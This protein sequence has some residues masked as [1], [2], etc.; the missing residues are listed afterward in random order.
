MIN[1]L[2]NFS[3]P[4]KDPILIFSLVL[5]IILLA[6]LVLKKLR[7]PSIIGLIIA[8]MV[9]G[10]QGFNVLLRDNSIVLFGTVGLLYIMFLAALELDLN[11]FR[12]N[13]YK[14]IV[15]GVLTFIVPLIIGLLF[16]H[17][18][19]G[20]GLMPSL[21]IASMF[22]THTMVAYPIVSKFGLTKNEAVNIAVGGTIITDS[23]VLLVLAIVTNSIQGD[24]N[25][26]F[27]LRLSGSLIIF[28]F[29]IFWGFPKIGYWFFKNTE[30]ESASQYIFVLAMVFLA[31]FMAELAGMEPIIGA[32]M[33]GFA[34][35]KLIPHSSVLMNR[36]EFVGNALFIPFFLISVGMLV[37]LKVLF[38]DTDTLLFAVLLTT[39]AVTTKWVAAILSRYILGLNRL[40]GNLLFGLSVSHAAAILAVVLTGMKLGLFDDKVLNGSILLILVTCLIA[41]F[42][43]EITGKKLAILEAENHEDNQEIEEKILI[44]LQNY[45]TY[46]RLLDF[47]FLVK[48]PKSTEPLYPLV[49]VKDDEESRHNI[50]SG[51]KF[52]EKAAQYASASGN[53]VQKVTR[54]DINLASGSTR[55]IKELLISDIILDWDV[56][57]K[58]TD[59]LFGS[60][61]RTMVNVNEQTMFLCNFIQPLNTLKKVILA[62]PP[63]AELEKGFYNWLNKIIIIAKQKG[64]SIVVFS[65]D[66]TYDKII[67]WI[68]K[69]RINLKISHSL[70]ENWTDFL[71]IGRNVQN[72]DLF[73]IVSARVGT[74]SYLSE[75]DNIPFHVNRHFLDHNFIILFPEQ[76]IS[77]E[78]DYQ[79]DG[80]EVSPIKENLERLEK[81]S[82]AVLNV[83]KGKKDE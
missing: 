37:D 24:L 25:F 9:I 39:V 81:F 56:N 23:A 66:L 43:T 61:I 68:T 40:Q 54:V 1:L 21:I 35:N 48:D 60:I 70:F 22:S 46:E 45:L 6:P 47:A 30:G 64:T 32:F 13:Q 2:F 18:Y 17:F 78:Y 49:V 5:F 28:V 42:T 52:L 38:Q 29:T 73:V 65:T 76:N 16:S 57:Y 19:W 36:I 69:K 50:A 33:A 44:P 83:L 71:I 77:K 62:I 34:L 55:A 72:D 27:W 51:A 80:L 53:L 41:S 10:P 4:L 82:N 63:N 11:E 59:L 20:Y 7:I 8:G 12:K 58:T 14:S 79:S 67:K 15:F 75:L 26:E 74:L 31:G 3:L